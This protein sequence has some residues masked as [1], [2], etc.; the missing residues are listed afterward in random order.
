M[1]FL[2]N[3]QQEILKKEMKEIQILMKDEDFTERID[4]ALKTFYGFYQPTCQT[5]EDM[6][7]CDNTNK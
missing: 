7:R 4:R 2:T 3:K 6:H 1:T 5:K